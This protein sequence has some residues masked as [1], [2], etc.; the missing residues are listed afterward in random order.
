MRRAWLAVPWLF[1]AL[2]D[3]AADQRPAYVGAA[4]LFGF[5]HVTIVYAADADVAT[6]RLCAERRAA[7]LKEKHGVSSTVVADDAVTPDQLQ[8]NL[9]LIGWDN[10]LIGTEAAPKPFGQAPGGRA[11][12]GSI[13]VAEG[14]DLLFA[15]ASPY[16]PQRR[17]VFWSRTDPEID[18]YLPMP[19]SG[20]DWAVFHACTI[21]R[22]GNFEE[23]STWP[24]KRNVYA[25]QDMATVRGK[26]SAQK[27]SAHYVL[28][29]VPESYDAAQAERVLTV[30]EAALRKAIE[31]VGDPGSDFR[32]ELFVYPDR[33]TKRAETDVNDPVHSVPAARSLYVTADFAEAASPHEEIHL[34][35]RKV[36]GP[37]YHT[38]LYEGL[39]VA[40]ER[41]NDLDRFAAIMVDRGN[42]PTV[43]SLLDEEAL[44]ARMA[45]ATAFPA[46]G[47]FVRWLLERG[48]KERVRSVYSAKP[49]TVDAL[50]TALGELPEGIEAT[51]ASWVRS[52]TANV[53]PKFRY[54]AALS[55]V[56][57]LLGLKKPAEALASADR[58]LALKPGD[59]TALLK[60]AQ[61]L[62]AGDRKPE[63]EAILLEV[64]R[65]PAEGE[66]L[67]Y[68]VHAHY[69]LALLLDDTRRYDEARKHYDA[70]LALP[71][72]DGSHKV[73][74]DALGVG[75]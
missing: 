69:Q 41:G 38:A 65:L 29:Y 68:V 30:R 16:N 73:A 56:D 35:A 32:I 9:F 71:D 8:G 63:A 44:R 15:A 3:A 27:K 74:N 19:I 28:H 62:A 25:E 75:P 7:Y 42:V 55:E 39:A 54:E 18:R 37:C 50:T 40:L 47:L 45:D 12:L 36:W 26:L 53:D 23:G 5:D 58:A 64:L 2:F 43:A 24:P 17:L 51:F 61:A 57:R 66:T 33:A 49:L 34:V 14:D 11:F 22:Q 46:S 20:S 48:G 60:R 72:V 70:I 13:L 52:R 6:N 21:L 4:A 1:L 59:S 67:L 31:L 10:R